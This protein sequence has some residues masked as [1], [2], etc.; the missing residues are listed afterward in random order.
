MV[1]QAWVRQ[2][3]TTNYAYR[4]PDTKIQILSKAKGRCRVP[5]YIIKLQV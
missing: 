2:T 5:A 1:S 4:K 3:M